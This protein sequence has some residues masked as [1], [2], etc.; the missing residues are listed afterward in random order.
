MFRTVKN[1]P[2]VMLC[3]GTATNAGQKSLEELEAEIGAAF[4]LQP[5][6]DLA[7]GQSVGRGQP[8]AVLELRRD[9]D[10]V[11]AQTLHLHRGLTQTGRE[12][13][14]IAAGFAPPK[15][16]HPHPQRRAFPQNDLH[17]G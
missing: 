12:T 15:G 17:D 8:P 4:S 16:M 9:A 1:G 5:S 11:A 7:Q 10:D 14:D 13:D 3:S 2:T 6:V